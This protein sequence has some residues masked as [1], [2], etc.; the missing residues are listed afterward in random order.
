MS[1]SNEKAKIL[2]VDD[3]EFHLSIAEEMLKND[4]IVITAQSGKKAIELL[5]KGLIPNI[6]LLDVLMPEMDGWET[7]ARIKAISCL[8]NASIAFLTSLKGGI[9][10]ERHAK[11]LGADAFIS[12]HISKEELIKKVEALLKHT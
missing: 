9:A 2:L 7:L 12:K 5:S 6:I 1:S 11:E 8:H 10:E 3:D 4:Y